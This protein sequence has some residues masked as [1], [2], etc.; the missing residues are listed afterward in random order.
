MRVLGGLEI[1]SKASLA[2]PQTA[3]EVGELAAILADISDDSGQRFGERLVNEWISAAAEGSIETLHLCA[4]AASL[5]I[6]GQHRL[7]RPLHEVL[8]SRTATCNQDAWLAARTLWSLSAEQPTSRAYPPAL[9][10]LSLVQRGDFS[11]APGRATEFATALPRRGPAEKAFKERLFQALKCEVSWRLGAHLLT[12]LLANSQADQFP[13]MFPAVQAWL[14]EH[15]HDP[16]VREQFLV[17]LLK[18]PN[19]FDNVHGEVAKETLDWLKHHKDDSS[20]RTQFLAFLSKLPQ[21]FDSMRAEVAKE[22]LD[23][24]RNHP[25]DTYVRAKLCDFLLRLTRRF[26]DLCRQAASVFMDWLISASV[27]GIPTEFLTQQA[28]KEVSLLS[29]ELIVK[30]G[31]IEDLSRALL[32][33]IKLLNEHGARNDIGDYVAA[34]VD[35]YHELASKSKS[36]ADPTAAYDILRSAKKAIGG[37]CDRNPAAIGYPWL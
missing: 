31:S 35:A 24:L 16:S 33:G 6:N 15:P 5:Q 37:W 25:E 30:A 36:L 26:E 1:G 19:G 29:F 8:I 2:A 23:W 20:V 4:L 9:N 22:T 18:L 11:I 12:W 14:R 17:F 3:R 7:A 32:W 13:S 10:L 21:R 34:M 28:V 27:A